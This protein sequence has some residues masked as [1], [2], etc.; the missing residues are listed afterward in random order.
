[1]VAA[2]D[3]SARIVSDSNPTIRLPPEAV[4]R[5]ELT[6]EREEQRVVP[7]EQMNAPAAI[8]PDPAVQHIADRDHRSRVREKP[9]GGPAVEIPRDDD[10]R[11]SS[12]FDHLGKGAK[13]LF[14]IDEET[15]PL[16]RNDLLAV[17]AGAE[18]AR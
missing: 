6:I 10:D 9:Q 12:G 7:D 2:T 1:M 8:A 5:R 4:D 14:P 18:Y 11:F 15:D 3:R 13:A 17:F 16:G